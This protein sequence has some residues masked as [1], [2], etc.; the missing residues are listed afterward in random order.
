MELLNVNTILRLGV[1]IS[2]SERIK[3]LHKKRRSRPIKNHSRQSSLQYKE[4]RFP[5]TAHSFALDLIINDS[6][7]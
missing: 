3:N 5:K 6:H 2:V 4:K 1:F 7:L